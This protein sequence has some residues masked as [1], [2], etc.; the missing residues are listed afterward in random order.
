MWGGMEKGEGEHSEGGR[1]S[2]LVR[3]D[4]S[5]TRIGAPSRTHVHR[6]ALAPLSPL[7]PLSPL[8]QLSRLSRVRPSSHSPHKLPSPFP[9]LHWIEVILTYPAASHRIL[10]SGGVCGPPDVTA[11]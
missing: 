8:S 3:S 6:L 5:E 9:L 1:G 10:N 7:V 2:R 11:E 4:R